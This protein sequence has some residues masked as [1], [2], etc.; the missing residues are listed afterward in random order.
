MLNIP[1]LL[2]VFIKYALNGEDLPEQ[3]RELATE[4]KKE[5][6][7]YARQQALLPFLQYFDIF[8]AEDVQ[9]LFLQSFVGYIYDDSRKKAEIEELL[10]LFEQNEIFCIPLKGIRT[11]EYY[12]AS[13]LR[14]MGDLDILYKKEQ[15]AVLRKTMGNVEFEYEGEASKHDHYRRD[16]LIVEMHKTLMPAESKAYTYFL[17]SWNRAVPQKGKSYVY[18]MS[19][20]DHYIY[21]LYHLTEHFLGGG[22]GIRMVLDIY[23]LSGQPG[24][25][26]YYIEN[27]LILLGIKEF[28]DHIL[29][30]ANVWFAATDYNSDDL[31]L[32]EYIVN[33]GVYGR[34]D[35]LIKNTRV[36]YRSRMHFLMH[37]IFP[38]YKVMQGVF[39]WLH[40]PLL[41][42]MSW[43]IRFKR[44][45]TKRRENIHLQFDRAS[46]MK[47]E[48]YVNIRKQKEF[49]K[50]MGL[51]EF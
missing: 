41:L 14:S 11:K 33:G 5:V 7:Q 32:E 35:N 29:H 50:R 10:D 25:D 38:P 34:E 6:I 47:A 42:P 4:E 44:V 22:I 51:S 15:T 48:E 26:W 30:L 17:E 13:E 18:Q 2:I 8:L 1:N 16:G 9:Q 36:R 23:I 12:P 31:E 21:T 46:K 49:L 27:E 24:M 45:W 20:E 37:V 19:L 43:V 40:T 3:Y 28:S 39:P